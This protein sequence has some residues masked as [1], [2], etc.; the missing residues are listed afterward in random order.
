MTEPN[1]TTVTIDRIAAG[2]DGVGR[3]SDGRVVFVPRTAP[4]DE[5]WVTPVVERPRYLRGEVAQLVAPSPD[6]TEPICSH[7]IEDDC[8]GCQLQHLNIAAQETAKRAIVGDA[9]RRIGGAIVDDPPLVPAV[10]P[11]H[12]RS[13]ITLSRADNGSFGFHRRREPGTVFTLVECAVASE[14]LSGMWRVLSNHSTLLPAGATRLTLREDAGRQGRGR[15][16][17]LLAWMPDGEAWADAPALAAELEAAGVRAALWRRPDRGQATLIVGDDAYPGGPAFE[18]VN[19]EMG[20][21]AREDALSRLGPV[22]GRHVWD[23]YAGVGETS[24]LLADR[25]ARVSSVEIDPQAVEAARVE[26]PDD[27]A[28][29]RF[30]GPVERVVGRLDAPD[31][32]VANPPRTG[33]G[34]EVCRALRDRPPQSIVYIS[35]DPA[36]LARDLQRL[37]N[38]FRLQAINAFDLFPHTAH[39]ETVVHLERL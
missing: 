5:V 34:R 27:E 11:W 17:H 10:S 37:G 13:K 23:L 22:V 4:G 15:E 33:L 39:V 16:M 12:Y 7:Y 8:G 19:P 21:M 31:L 36:T 6:R 2:G 1:A 3:W 9:L 35:C 38:A 29:S 30:V 26:R 28:L 20:R 14:A 25:G 24:R 32:V 18:Q